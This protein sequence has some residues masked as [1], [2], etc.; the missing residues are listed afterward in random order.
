MNKY[1]RSLSSSSSSSSSLYNNIIKST[2][3]NIYIYPKQTKKD[4]DF[5]KWNN[6]FDILFNTIT[7]WKTKICLLNKIIN[8]YKWGKLKSQ[9]QLISFIFHIYNIYNKHYK[10]ILKYSYI[11]YECEFKLGRLNNCIDNITFQK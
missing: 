11:Y 7:H 1:E 8:Q 10:T 4:I 5:E 9:E 3:I 6:I 2:A